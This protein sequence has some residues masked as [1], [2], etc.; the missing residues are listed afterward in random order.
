MGKKNC[1]PKANDRVKTQNK[2]EIKP[3]KDRLSGWNS[4]CVP[5]ASTMIVHPLATTKSVIEGITRLIGLGFESKNNR[6]RKRM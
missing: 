2:K 5:V 3:F 1:N 4:A 6:F